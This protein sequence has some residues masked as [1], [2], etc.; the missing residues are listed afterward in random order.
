RPGR[1]PGAA[2]GA[3]PRGAGQLYPVDVNRG[4]T[5]GTQRQP[6]GGRH[7]AQL[8][9]RTLAVLDTVSG[10][11]W[12]TRVDSTRSLPGLPGLGGDVEP[13]ASVGR[14]V[15]TTSGL[16]PARAAAE[17][18]SAEEPEVPDV[19]T[20]TD[21]AGD[22]K[23]AL[24]VGVDGSVYAV[25]SAGKVAIVRPEGPGFTEPEYRELGQALNSVRVTA[26][27]DQLVVLDE[28][29]GRLILPSGATVELG[30]PGE[31][32]IALQRSGPSA[33]AVL[34]ATGGSLLAVAL[35]S[36][37]VETLYEELSGPPAEPVRLSG[38]VHAA[39]AGSAGGYARSCGDTAMEQLSVEGAEVLEQPVFRVNRGAIVLNDLRTG[40]VWDL[41]ERRR[42]D[43]WTA[44]KPPPLIESSD[45]EHT[46]RDPDVLSE[47]P[48]KAVDDVLG[49][50]PGRTTLLHVLDND[51]DPSGSILSI[52]QVSAPDQPTVSLAIAPDG[53]TVAITVTAAGPPVH[54]TYT[55]DDGYFTSEASVTVHIRTPEQ[56]EVPTLREGYQREGYAVVASGR[57]SI[58]VLADWRDFD[59]DPIALVDAEVEAGSVTTR[60]DGSLEYLAPAEA[61]DQTIDYKVSDGLGDPASSSVDVTVL[62]VGSPAVAP[63]TRPDVARGQVGQPIVIHPL[64]NDVPG[65]D[66]ANPTAELALAGDVGSPPNAVVVTNLQAGTVVLTAARPGPYLLEYTV[67]FGNAPF[68]KGAIRVD[69]V[70]APN[71]PS[72]PVA[73][74]DTAVLQGQLPTTVDVLANDFDPAGGVLSVL[75]AA[76]VSPDAH[77]Q[78]AIVDGQWLRINALN[79]LNI[80]RPQTVRYL[81]SNGLTA[82]V[83]GEVTVTLLP[84]PADT[85][86]VPADDYATVRS[87]ESIT[88]AV[89]DNDTNPGGAP[90]TLAANVADASAP[91]QLVVSAPGAEDPGI[92][93]VTGNLV[94][95]YAPDVPASQP[96]TVDYVVQNAD[97]DQAVGQLHLT[98]VPKPTEANPNRPPAPAP[99]EARVFAGQT[100]TVS[101]PTSGVDVD[102]DTVTLVGIGSAP[103]L[104]RIVS[105]S[106]TSFT[107][108][109]FPTSAGTDSFTYVVQDRYGAVGQAGVRI[110]VTPP[111]SP[112]PPVAVD[113][114]I[115]AAPGARVYLDVLANDVRTPGDTVTILPLADR[116]PSL[117]DGVELV[118]PTGP[119]VATA[120]GLTGEPLVIVYAITN[121]IGQ[122][123]VATVTIRSQEDYNNPPKAFDAFAVPELG[124]L[125]VSVDL[126]TRLADPDGD[127]D[128]LRITQVF[129]EGATVNGTVVTLPVTEA[130]RTVTYEVTDGG[131]AT[132]LG[133]IH[134]AAPGSG[135]PYPRPGATITIGR[136]STLTVNIADYL[137]VPSGRPVRLTTVD[138]IWAAPTTGLTA[139]ND[140]EASIVLTSVNDYTGPGALVFEVTDGETLTDSLGRTAVVSIPVQVGP[141]TP[142]LHCPTEPI[143][144][145]QGGPVVTVDVTTVC[146]VWVA[147]PRTAPN[148]RY[149]ARWTDPAEGI[150]LAGSGE[151]TLRLT[152]DSE[153]VPGTTGVIE[154]GVEGTEAVPVS[155]PVVVTA[156]PL[157]AV[158]PVRVD[159]V[160]A[161][162][163]RTIDLAPYVRSPL[164][165]PS[166]SVIAVEHTGGMPGTATFVGS[167][168][169]LTPDPAAHGE[170]TFV[171]TLTDVSATGRQD[172]YVTGQITLNVL[173][174]PDAPGTPVIDEELSRSV[175]ISWSTPANN[176]APIDSYEVSWSGGRQTCAASPCLITGL[177]NG[178]TYT[179]TVRAHNL[180]GW[181]EPSG[182]SGPAVPDTVPGAVTGLITSNPQDGTLDLSWVAP[183]NEGTPVQRYE[184]SW[185]GGGQGTASGT[186]FTATGLDNNTQYT[187]TVIAVNAKG[188]GP[189][190]Q[191]VGQSAGAPAAPA[192]PTFTTVN[193]ADAT[194]RAVTVSWP[195]VSPNGPGPT[196][197]TLTRTGGGT[198]VVC[199]NVTVTSCPDDGIAN[200]GTIYTYTV[201][202]ANA[203][204]AGGLGHVSP[205][206]PGT[207]ME[208]TATPDP[209]TGFSV[210]PTGVDGQALVTFNAPASHGAIS[211]TTCTWNGNSCGTWSY[212][213]GGQSGITRTITGLPNGQMVTVTLQTCNGSSGGYGAGTPC[214]TPVSATV[215]TY[216]QMHSLSITGGGSG[217]NVSFTVSVNPNGKPA[218][219]RVQSWGRDQTFTTGVGVWSQTFTDNIGYSQSD[220]VTV[221]V[222]DPG[223]STLTQSATFNSE[224]PPPSVTVWVG[225]PCGPAVG[226]QCAGDKDGDCS[227]TCWYIGV[228]TANF[229][230][231]VTCTFNSSL[232]SAGFVSGTWGP[233]ESRRSNNWYGVRS[234][235]V[236]VTCGGVTGTR[237]PWNP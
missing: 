209:I 85:K 61:G 95:Y 217:P 163:S 164:R 131:G 115:T 54:F 189:A 25:S 5:L 165:D 106:A 71:S 36:G 62:T 144:V 104:G 193:S 160:H 132:A 222:S 87:G 214:N 29:T 198:V 161:G 4:V 110:G 113:D 236:S 94:R 158:S 230:G 196:T 30:S 170:M 97:G 80:G 52:T 96:V 82:P 127:Q 210:T 167:R 152:A 205:P 88:V 9:G 139:A 195:A 154:I 221:T 69:V 202:A 169:T 174:V 58:P 176:G 138:R 39:W 33:P 10:R 129:D 72:P 15:L 136:N 141:E 173:G 172:R 22:A 213:V 14:E 229:P 190:T 105:V 42:I 66:P 111:G 8:V 182:Q 212:P 12:A 199:E 143:G 211:T 78:V 74:P 204:A 112:Q 101:V 226:T 68:A 194:S 79:L 223:R 225:E 237:N 151:H 53:Q 123:S 2:G 45:E 235:W 232:G 227:N 56:N 6:I 124:A 219:V 185:S 20:P 34:V 148:L 35:D 183:P 140:G 215:T 18:P 75:H 208:A 145:V 46:N 119:I 206:S 48:P 228:T 49:A 203:A 11:M 26:V 37:E 81:V 128:D 98:V 156:A 159:G 31:A 16:V 134:V 142:V 107:Y 216:G 90:M 27:G 50:R 57:L 44:V 41:D 150:E 23:A 65:S 83:A 200:D 125:T 191:V 220:T 63:I 43:N 207:Q 126:K 166:I 76:P 149:S 121:G 135:P 118:G 59:G 108:Q 114:Q 153:A 179:F 1:P 122:P 77:L 234:G 175:R 184:I 91:G 137:V 51:S 109:A 60:T 178:T 55:I 28:T 116:N 3:G 89:L 181:S 231:S 64:N 133:L 186:S 13:T 180:V 155:L 197:Y 17:E 224:P 86:P 24:A 7:Q 70:P 177:T 201:T 19:P 147:D 93:T 192:G 40:Q 162:D 117:P 188:P 21:P 67:A 218:T 99:V 171:V 38:C 233:N 92:A 102:G 168:V 146:H 73:M 187:F 100:V 32:G 47:Q 130:P 103:S 157:A 84:D 120:P